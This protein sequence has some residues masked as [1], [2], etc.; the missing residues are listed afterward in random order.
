MTGEQ[1][2]VL[3]VEDSA[4]QAMRLT[5]LLE[6]EGMRVHCSVSAEEA[7]DYLSG[8]RPDL[9]V[10]DYH[11]PSMQGDELCRQIRM[12]PATG[13]ILMLILTDDVQ[14]VIER[15]GLESGADDHLPKSADADGLMARIYALLR[16]Q[17]RRPG[18]AVGLQPAYFQRHNVV[19]VDDSPTF[20]ALV[21]HEL[22]HDGYGMTTFV[23]GEEAL[24]Y[25]VRE[26]CDCILVDLM[27]PGMD[28]IELCRRLD[29]YRSRSGLWF[30]VLMVTSRDSKEDMMRALEAGADDFVGKSSDTTI[31]RARIRALLRRKLQRDEHERISVE[32]RSKELEVLR[33]RSERE[34]AERR[35]AVIEELEATNRQ[36][37]ETQAQL[38]QAAKM[39]S[40]G[41]LVAGIAH[42]V[43][44]P[45]AFVMS[46]LDTVQRSLDRV[47]DSVLT[48][49]PD[50][51]RPAFDKARVRLTDMRGG[52]ERVR[53]LVTKLRTFSRLDE[54]EFKQADMRDSIESVLAILHHRVA[55]GVMVHTDYAANNMIWCHPAPL[56]QVVMNLV[57]N[58]LDAVDG[59]GQV[60]VRTER[61]QETY[62]IIVADDGPGLA[63]GIRDRI[64]E[65]FFTTKP[66]GKGMGLGLAISYRIV[67]SH[68]GMIEV[69][70]REGRG[71]RFVVSIPLGLREAR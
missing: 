40:L 64:F 28:G 2:H 34:S 46:H 49:L 25:V 16:T 54:G 14:D 4:T 12:N 71:V 44:N 8:S 62:R 6:D 18:S 65:P 56:N 21:R 32:F 35:A 68:E 55:K 45:L 19:I 33:E 63:A 48:L 51:D 41:E 17:R 43:N 15:Q 30:P 60:N 27:M 69:E 20:L 36:L 9:I 7:L 39:A 22:S 23:H 58:A 50:A 66:V 24:D 53:D 70:P 26:G 47:A 1:T 13:D 3:I 11:L 67:Q 37:K 38:I 57:S 52:L 31:L 10:I 61:D 42:E 29:D 59:N 5:A